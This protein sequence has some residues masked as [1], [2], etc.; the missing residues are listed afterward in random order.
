MT[1]KGEKGRAVTVKR[2]ASKAVHRQGDSDLAVSPV[3]QH[4]IVVQS[5]TNASISFTAPGK[6]LFPRARRSC[7]ASATD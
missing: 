1:A 3:P 7:L 6:G 2:D 5:W 4:R